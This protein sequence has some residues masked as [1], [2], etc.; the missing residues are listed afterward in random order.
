[1][2]KKSFVRWF[3]VKIYISI[4][5]VLFNIIMCKICLE[6]NVNILCNFKESFRILIILV[7]Y[8]GSFLERICLCKVM[9]VF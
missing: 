8:I 1:M 7:L 9:K 6:I 4:Y 2:I 3:K 5:R